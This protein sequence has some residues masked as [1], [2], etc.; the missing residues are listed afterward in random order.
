MRSKLESGD[1]RD[2]Q[3]IRVVE[4]RSMLFCDRLDIVHPSYCT[5]DL[6]LQCFVYDLS[7]ACVSIAYHSVAVFFKEILLFPRQD[8]K[9]EKSE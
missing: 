5:N 7:T 6:C 2:S 4:G 3:R 1:G 9:L 8:V